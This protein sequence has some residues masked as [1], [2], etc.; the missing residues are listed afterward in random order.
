M[1]EL[2]IKFGQTPFWAICR[3]GERSKIE[4]IVFSFICAKRFRSTQEA[5]CTRQEIIEYTKLDKSQISLAIKKLIK[6]NWLE[7]R[8]KTKWFIPEIQPE[9]VDESSTN[10]DENLVDDFSTKVDDST[11][12]VEDS[13]TKVDESSTN[14]NSH[15]RNSFSSDSSD[16]SQTNR[17]EAHI[18]AG[19]NE[20]QFPI[21]E[22][23]EKFPEVEFTPSDFGFIQAAVKESDK[24]AWLAT[25]G[26]YELNYKPK[27][28]RYMPNKVA[29]LLSV[30]ENQKAKIEKENEVNNGTNKTNGSKY[31]AKRTDADIFRESADFYNNPDN[32]AN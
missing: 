25:I 15:I 12:D 31:P 3:F 13:S 19:A 22:L 1:A 21:K 14:K 6:I 23:V 8:S 18:N 11:T 24:A 16:L 10:Q 2:N 9:K 30:F 27:L 5:D 7:S 32:F 29:N 26:I 17:Q 4:I 20:F 28:D